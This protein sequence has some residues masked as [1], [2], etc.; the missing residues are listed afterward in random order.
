MSMNYLKTTLFKIIPYFGNYFPALPH[1]IFIT[2]VRRDTTKEKG[3]HDWQRL[4][5]CQNSFFQR[6]CTFYP[7]IQVFYKLLF[8]PLRVGVSFYFQMVGTV[9]WNKTLF[10]QLVGAAIQ[11]PKVSCLQTQV[12]LWQIL[13]QLHL[14][15]QPALCQSRTV[16][17]FLHLTDKVRKEKKSLANRIHP[18]SREPHLISLSFASK[19]ADFVVTVNVER[20]FFRLSECHSKFFFV[21]AYFFTHFQSRGRFL[22]VS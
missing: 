21:P 20:W 5:L 3:I 12:I 10:T 2:G 9:S 17:L 8:C 1:Q 11:V 19:V 13:Q 18:K 4:R 7:L 6:V 14:K 16:G 15:S 22:F